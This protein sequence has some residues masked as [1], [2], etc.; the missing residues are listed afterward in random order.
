MHAAAV[1]HLLK[2]QGYP[3]T[4]QRRAV[5]RFLD[6]NPDHPTAAQIYS[7]VTSVYPVVSRATVYNTLTLLESL[8]AVCTLRGANG[9]TRYDPN[10][11]PHHHLWCD[12]CGRLE[13]VAAEL[14]TIT[15]RGRETVGDVRLAGRCGACARG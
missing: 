4:P 3:L 6:G 8:N 10:T 1:E 12:V 9:E 5:L 13:D 2:T 15:L 14:V 7:A 11:E